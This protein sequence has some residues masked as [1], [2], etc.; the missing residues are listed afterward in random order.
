MFDLHRQPGLGRQRFMQPT[1]GLDAGLLVGREHE[2]IGVQFLSLPLMLIQ[3]EDPTRFESEIGVAWKNPTAVLPRT[4]GVLVEPSPERRAAQLSDQSTLANVL[5]QFLQTPTRE[6]D[7]MGGGQFAGQSFNLYDEFWG[8]KTG[9]DP[10][11]GV[12]PSR[13]VAFRKSACAIG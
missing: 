13:P 10:V 3:I 4:N 12:L 6:R 9:G 11:G 5:A 8:K 2:F 1:A 7:V